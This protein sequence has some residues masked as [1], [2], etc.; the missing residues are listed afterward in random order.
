MQT[1]I[2]LTEEV[3]RFERCPLCSQPLKKGSTT[4]FSCGFST[5]APT[6]TSVWIDPV[7]YRLT[8]TQSQRQQVSPEKKVKPARYVHPTRKNPN[9]TTPIPPRA[10][11]TTT[12]RSITEEPT[13]PELKTQGKVTRRLPQIDEVATHPTSNQ[14]HSLATSRSLVSIPSQVDLTTFIRSGQ[15]DKHIVLASKVEAVSWTAGDAADSAHAR[16]IT[17]RRKHK[18]LHRV[19]SLN[20]IDRF[21]W[22][23]LRPGHLEFI[24][25]LGGTI[26]LVA[27]TCLLLFVTAFSFEW[28]TPG[29]Y[30]QASSISSGS[31]Q[32]QRS[33]STIITSSKLVL[34]RLDKGPILPGQ[35]IELQG[36]GFSRGAHI[37]FLFDGN[38]QLFDQIGRSDSTQANAQGV[39]TAT[40]VLGINLPWHPGHHS[41]NAQDLVTRMMATLYIDLAQAPIGKG[42]SNTPVPSSPP[43][44]TPVP[45]IAGGQPTPVGQTPI[46][47]TPTPMPIT[48]TPTLGTTPSP[49]ATSPTV[50]PTAGSTPGVT[51]TVGTTGGSG[52][53]N[54]LDDP[55][56]NT[57]IGKQLAHVSP[58]IWFM[59]ACYGLS[60]IL[61]GLAGVLHKCRQ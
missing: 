6:S 21:R 20:P 40:V 7:V 56:E 17:T 60:M 8:S 23:L 59:I 38:Q 26:L 34:I 28:I 2:W 18:G 39:F 50:V 55:G 24:L 22:W 25:W 54:A 1:D 27:V 37:R 41:I 29:F 10:S 13:R 61:L 16:L 42:I 31:T 5:S 43:F 32:G 49:T 11:A 30:N 4:C 53:G 19:F 9:P 47:V 14:N 58:W 44:V 52:L 36:K 15:A 46:P 57:Y 3:A 35:S 51:T 48:P 45:T 33:Q 12:H